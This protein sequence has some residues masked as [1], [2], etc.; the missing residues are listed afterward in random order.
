MNF[1]TYYEM[2]SYNEAFRLNNRSKAVIRNLVR[3]WLFPTSSH[4]RD[5]I[6]CVWEEI[7]YTNAVFSTISRYLTT[8]DMYRLMWADNEG[9]VNSLVG[10]Y[11]GMNSKGTGYEGP[12][13]HQ[14]DRGDLKPIKECIGRYFR[15]LSRELSSQGSVTPKAAKWMITRSDFFNYDKYPVGD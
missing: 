7:H 6:D 13:R 15:E 12:I 4:L 5:W 14:L 10:Y 1:E 8:S 9:I 2:A 3:I 11:R